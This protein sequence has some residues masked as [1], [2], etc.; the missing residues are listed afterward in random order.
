[1]ELGAV[2]GGDDGHG[3]GAGGVEVL[4]IMM[5]ALAA[6]EEPLWLTTRAVMEPSPVRVS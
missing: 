6:E 4:R 5:P 3:F 2:A 1:L